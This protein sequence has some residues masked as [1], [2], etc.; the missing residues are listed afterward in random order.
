MIDRQIAP[1][2]SSV[3]TKPRCDGYSPRHSE[4]GPLDG[5]PSLR[6][7]EAEILRNAR[8]LGPAKSVAVLG[9]RATCR[10]WWVRI[11]RQSDFRRG[12]NAEALQAY[13]AMRIA[14]F[15]DI[16]GLQAW[17][18]WRSIPRN[19]NQRLPDR[20]VFAIDL[21]SGLG[22]STAVLAH[23]CAPGSEILGLEFQAEFVEHARR[24]SFW[25]RDHHLANVS[26]A[27]RNVLEPWHDQDGRLVPHRAVD[28]VNAIG[29]VGCHF[30]R[31]ALRDL[32]GECRRV[33]RPDGLALIDAENG[34]VGKDEL[35]DAFQ[36]EGFR[37]VGQ[38]RS[39]WLDRGWQLCLRKNP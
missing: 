34:G 28:L 29:A 24:R 22:D 9:C 11:R 32:A 13:Q 1:E 12:D 8:R 39:C 4:S 36:N 37:C 31:D 25:N 35:V 2:S 7:T 16:N 20:P 23:Y 19:L 38:A 6:L 33:L 15:N 5:E 14:E 21:C 18:N 3:L 26:F 27:A 17:A 10:E 30:N